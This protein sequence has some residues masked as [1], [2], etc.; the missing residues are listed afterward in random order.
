MKRP[1]KLKLM[2]LDMGLD[3]SSRLDGTERRKSATRPLVV[4]APLA[5]QFG[6]S[7]RLK[8]HHAQ[9]FAS[10]GDTTSFIY[11][12]YRSSI[13]GTGEVLTHPRDALRGGGLYVNA[14][15]PG[16][17]VVTCKIIIIIIRFLEN[18]EMASTVPHWNAPYLLKLTPLPLCFTPVQARAGSK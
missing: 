3:I 16:Q 4:A 6:G 9:I 5:Y 17:L 13:C 10:C 12:G 18:G 2:A 14:L 8:V 15:R 1:S 11:M 7:P